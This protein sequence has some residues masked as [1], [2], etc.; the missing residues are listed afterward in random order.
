MLISPIEF[1]RLAIVT[2]ALGYIFSGMIPRSKNIL[3]S[4]SRF[5]WDGIKIAI[6]IS[7]PAVLLH[8]LAH[9]FAAIF[10]GLNTEF[11]AQYLGLTLGI[12][13]KL[14]GSPFLIF[15][16]GYVS[17]SNPTSIQSGIIA[18]MGPFTNLLLW[19]IP[20]LLLKY[21]TYSNNTAIVLYATKKI[22]MMLFMFNMIPLPPFDGS[23][24]L[25]GLLG[26]F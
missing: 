14:V 20:A 15:I 9:K 21:K 2:L 3:E 19:I 12:V 7:A 16:P 22:N 6:L 23:K 26:L 1:L 18:F 10:F 4:Y 5:D 11:F 13:L 25:S 8:E 17:I 24:V